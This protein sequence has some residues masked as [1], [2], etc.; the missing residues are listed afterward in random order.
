MLLTRYES[1]IP[2]E[3][4]LTYQSEFKST[5]PIE[6]LPGGA[7]KGPSIADGSLGW[8]FITNYQRFQVGNLTGL[9]DP[10]QLKAAVETMIPAFC[11]QQINLMRGYVQP[12]GHAIPHNLLSR[13]PYSQTGSMRPF[14][15]PEKYGIPPGF[16]A[17]NFSG[18]FSCL[19]ERIRQE[20][21][22][23]IA[24]LVLL[25]VV[26]ACAVIACFTTP[27]KAVLPREPSSIAAQASMLTG[28]EL[29]RRLREEE[30][31]S[32]KDTRI[33]DQRFGLGWWIVRNKENDPFDSDGTDRRE[34]RGSVRMRWGIDVG[35]PD[36]KAIETD[37]RYL[38]RGSYT[39]DILL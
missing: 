35:T 31:H 22:P 36:C 32:V 6:M 26:L 34:M 30:V 23:T 12:P 25:T 21:G 33:W 19:E 28:S 3:E 18:T 39:H 4:T 20:K 5:A 13:N 17:V 37:M 29:V 2:C 9:L 16:Q 11:A 8:K 27:L 14:L 10:E 1:L 38:A 24:L 15:R 7:L